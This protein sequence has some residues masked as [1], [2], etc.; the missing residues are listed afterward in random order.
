VKTFKELTE[1]KGEIYDTKP[2]T[3]ADAIDPEVLIQ[4]FGRLRYTQLRD[5]VLQTLERMS[6]MAKSGS[7]DSIDY[8]MANLHTFLAAVKDVEKEMAKPQWKKKITQLKRAG[9]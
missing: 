7:W 6:K 1:V 9:K 8:T 3:H 4:G 5:K 2:Q